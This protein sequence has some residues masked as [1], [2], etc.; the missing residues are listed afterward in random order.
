MATQRMP[1]GYYTL[2][3]IAVCGFAGLFAFIA[4]AESLASRVWAVVFGLVAVLFNPI[5]PIYLTRATWFDLDI[6]TAIV[7]AAHL[8]VVRLEWLQTKG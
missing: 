4:W 3:R 5:V 1:Y 8:A 7:F 6:G 2:T